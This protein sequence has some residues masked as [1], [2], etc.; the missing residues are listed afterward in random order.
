MEQLGTPALG[1]I[2]ANIALTV[3]ACCI[4]KPAIVRC[5]VVLFATAWGGLGRL[6]PHHSGKDFRYFKPFM[7]RRNYC[8]LIW[9]PPYTTVNSTTVLKCFY[10]AFRMYVRTL[11]T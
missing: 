8:V 3:C 2:F 4:L 1:I 9:I 5:M 11:R 6:S 10:T 7:T